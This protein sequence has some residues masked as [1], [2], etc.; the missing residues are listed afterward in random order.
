MEK[1]SRLEKLKKLIDTKFGRLTV[2]EV[3][4]TTGPTGKP[5]YSLNCLCECGKM[6]SPKLPALT[7]GTTISCGCFRKERMRKAFFARRGNKK[8]EEMTIEDWK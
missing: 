1:E 3:V 7:S 2:I 4:E 6:T 5:N 8:T